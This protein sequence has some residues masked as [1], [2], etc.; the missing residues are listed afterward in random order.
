MYCSNFLR[1]VWRTLLAAAYG[2]CLAAGNIVFAQ[3]A[4][5]PPPAGCF[6]L[7]AAPP[8]QQLEH[9]KTDPGYA[10]CFNFLAAQQKRTC[11]P[12]PAIATGNP[13]SIAPAVNWR[14]CAQIAQ[15]LN[16][17]AVA[18]TLYQQFEAQCK[19]THAQDACDAAQNVGQTMQ[20]ATDTLAGAT[21]AL[22]PFPG[23]PPIAGSPKQ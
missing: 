4:A 8:A 18:T 5:P 1:V 11:G 19:A 10:N 9:A 6:S 12:Q 15:T 16:D 14:G 20:F 2:F 7:D 23:Q 22:P 3:S 13:A 21:P 17:L